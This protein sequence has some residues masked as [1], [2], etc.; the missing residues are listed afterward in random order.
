VAARYGIPDS[1]A[2]F[3]DLLARPDIQA[4][5]VYLHNNLHM[6]LSAWPP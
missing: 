3:H 4:V 1:Y 5:D 2:D 6:P